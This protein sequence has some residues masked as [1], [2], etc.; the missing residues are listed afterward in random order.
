MPCNNIIITRQNQIVCRTMTDN[1][2]YCG[3]RTPGPE[4]ADRRFYDAITLQGGV[5]MERL[6]LFQ[7]LNL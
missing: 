6:P 7:T 2:H 3:G 4:A 1:H 5:F